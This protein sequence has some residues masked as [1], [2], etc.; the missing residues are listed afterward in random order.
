M[1][2]RMHDLVNQKKR[3]FLSG[4]FACFLTCLICI[5]I[6]TSGCETRPSREYGVF[7]GINGE[8]TDRLKDYSLAVIEPSEF[9]AVQ[10]REF[11]EAGKTI[12][13]YINIGAVEEY[14]P[15]YERFKDITLSV[16]E[17]WPLERWT[18]V[19]DPEW[20]AFVVD[21]LAKQYADIGVD[22]F[23]LDNADVYFHY[24]TENIFQG[25]CSILKGLKGYDLPL[26]VN[27][28]DDFV[29]RCMDE[30]IALSLFDGINQE[31]VFTTI[32]FENESYGKQKEEETLYFKDYL[33]RAK[34]CGLSVYLL[35]YFADPALSKEIDD[36]CR[37]NGFFW[38]NAQ[39]LELR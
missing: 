24:P 16:Y 37:G 12:Y 9:E 6:A 8:E 10:I 30:G 21:E 39:S 27:G 33:T 31:T 14:R 38:Y 15:Y 13:G 34:D 29:S 18:D 25:L 2:R 28:G 32:V 26:I 7:L 5:L 1:S 17:N 22:G 35:E 20:Q 23:F 36:Y 11:H 3:I 4:V 19:S